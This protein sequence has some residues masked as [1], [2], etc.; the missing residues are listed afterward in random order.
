MPIR[1][2][3]MHQNHVF[4]PLGYKIHLVEQLPYLMSTKC[5]YYLLS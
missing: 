4:F 2:A 5:Q 3:V 1:D